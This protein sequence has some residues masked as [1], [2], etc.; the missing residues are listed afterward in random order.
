MVTQVPDAARPARPT[1][2]ALLPLC[3]VVFAVLVH[4]SA[5]GPFAKEIARDLG[6]TVPLIGQVSTLLL[7]TMAAG[8]L[9]AGPLADHFGHRRVILLGLGLLGLSAAIMGLAPAYPAL[10]VGA[11]VAGTGAPIM[12]VAVAVAAARYAGDGRREALSRLQATQTSGS[13]LGAPLLTAV[14]AATIW[15]GA[16]VVVLAAYLLAGALIALR[17]ARDP[18]PVG[19]FTARTVLV[20]YRP[21]LHDRGMLALYGASTLRALGW[22]GPFT[23]LGAFYAER[24]GLALGRIGLA[25]MIAS[26]GMFLG[27][28][29]AGRWL[30]GVDLRR[31]FAATTAFLALCWAAV[32]TLPLATPQVVAVATVAAFASGI[33]WIALTTLLAAETAAGLGTTMTLNGSAFALGSA[34]GSAAGGLLIGVGGYALLGVALPATTLAAALLVWRPGQRLRAFRERDEPATVALTADDGEQY[35]R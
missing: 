21:L 35:R 20:A 18:R 2:G 15:R 29:A 7:A 16:Y 8:G 33:G 13:I 3:L 24:H 10:L 12:G 9:L 22:M 4:A 25:Y 23:Y 26:I 19:H 6:T 27:N 34:L 1:W 31:A 5:I 14:A 28:L 11:L 30:G 17:L 32:F